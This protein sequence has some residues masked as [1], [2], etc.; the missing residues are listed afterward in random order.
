M[1]SLSLLIGA[2]M[3]LTLDCSLRDLLQQALQYHSVHTILYQL[4]ELERCPD[5]EY[6]ASEC[7]KLLPNYED[8]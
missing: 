7:M 5:K 1:Y 8:N 6:F 3:N 4:A 2:D